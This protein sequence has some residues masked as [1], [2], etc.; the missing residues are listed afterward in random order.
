M[1]YL[2]EMVEANDGLVALSLRATNL[3]QESVRYLAKAIEKN[4]NILYLD[5]GDNSIG[6]VGATQVYRVSHDL[7]R[8]LLLVRSF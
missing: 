3:T 2:G 7:K 4:A 6:D 8:Y 1:Q 5:V